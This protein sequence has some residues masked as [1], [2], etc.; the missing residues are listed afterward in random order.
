MDVYISFTGEVKSFGKH[1]DTDD[2]LM[3]GSS[4]YWKHE[5]YIIR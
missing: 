3:I 1:K 5:I 4:R 2:V